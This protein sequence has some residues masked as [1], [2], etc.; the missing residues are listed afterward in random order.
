M[1]ASGLPKRIPN[2]ASEIAK[3]SLK[4]VDAA[5]SFQIPHIPNEELKIRI[6]LHSGE[7]RSRLS[8][9]EILKTC[10]SYY[11][12]TM[13]SITGRFSPLSKEHSTKWIIYY[14]NFKIS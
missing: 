2:H 13:F 6:G 8:N 7:N 12:S 5:K 1:V 14:L 3:M 9:N 10:Y 4:I 11:V